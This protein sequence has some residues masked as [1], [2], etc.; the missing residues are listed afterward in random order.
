MCLPRYIQY[1][2]T[3]GPAKPIT[4]PLVSHDLSA[5]GVTGF[6]LE[7]IQRGPAINDEYVMDLAFV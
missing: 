5:S 1:H 3:N 6:D 2:L 4:K 7:F